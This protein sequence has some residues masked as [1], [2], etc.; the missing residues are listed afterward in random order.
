MQHAFPVVCDPDQISRKAFPIFNAYIID[1]EGVLRTR[2]PGTLSARPSLSM[3]LE[4]LCK[5]EGVPA[6]KPR[7]HDDKKSLPQAQGASVNAEDVLTVQWMWSHDRIAAGDSF[8]L[9][10]LPVLAQGFHVYAPEE[11][12]MT[13]FKLELILPKGIEIKGALRYAQAQKLRDPFLEV[14]VLQYE[15]DVPMPAMIFQAT[16]ALPL[17]KCVLKAKLSYQACND[18]LCYPPAQKV[19]EMPIQVVSKQTKRNQVA[20]WKNW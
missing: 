7:R 4:E 8:K 3:I 12:R 6:V 16:E 15:G 13:A 5:V 2:V 19:I 10:F 14:D 9:A 11:K 1:K 20:G 18:V 17:G